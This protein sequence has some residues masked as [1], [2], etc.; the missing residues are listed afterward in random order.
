MKLINTLRNSSNK[1]RKRKAMNTLI[2]DSYIDR[3]FHGLY[4]IEGIEETDC[5]IFHFKM[6]ETSI[7]FYKGIYGEWFEE[8]KGRMVFKKMQYNSSILAE[9]KAKTYEYNKATELV[10]EN[11][12]LK[13]VA[14]DEAKKIY[15]KNTRIYCVTFHF[16][17]I[18]LEYTQL[19]NYL[20]Y[21]DENGNAPAG[22]YGL[23]L[24]NITGYMSTYFDE[25]IEASIFIEA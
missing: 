10:A 14:I 25:N 8:N 1:E 12:T 19:K 16:G 15:M 20:D 3:Q 24:A 21:E 18:T 7:R 5:N 6:D 22:V 9:L 13:K 23:E 4:E 17:G 11:I 2:L